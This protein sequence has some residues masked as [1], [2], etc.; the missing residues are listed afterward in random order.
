MEVNQYCY[1]NTERSNKYGANKN[2]TWGQTI[3]LQLYVSMGIVF[4]KEE[5]VENNRGTFNLFLTAVL[6]DRSD[7]YEYVIVNHVKVNTKLMV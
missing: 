2:R 1:D 3:L 7:V 6:L 4:A 5:Y